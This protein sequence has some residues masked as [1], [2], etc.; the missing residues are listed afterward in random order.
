MNKLIKVKQAY[1]GFGLQKKETANGIEFYK[2]RFY[3]YTMTVAAAGK[4]T[5]VI[6]KEKTAEAEK[7]ALNASFKTQALA[8]KAIKEFLNKNNEA[9]EAAEDAA[10]AEEYKKNKT[11]AAAEIEKTLESLKVKAEKLEAEATEAEVTFLNS[12]TE[13]SYKKAKSLL[14]EK[15]ELTEK[16]NIVTLCIEAL[17]NKGYKLLSDNLYITVGY[18]H[19]GKKEDNTFIV[20]HFSFVLNNSTTIN[21]DKK[22]F[23]VVGGDRIAY[24]EWYDMEAAEAAE[25]F[26]E[27]K[28]QLK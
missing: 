6:I 22:N 19:T 14:A 18:E 26:E 12:L 7:I 5:T 1:L 23:E 4:V 13:E 10:R 24:G 27:I 2:N 16:I 15:K 9:A 17:K 11:E 20:S 21:I 28:K 3:P 8:L 25:W